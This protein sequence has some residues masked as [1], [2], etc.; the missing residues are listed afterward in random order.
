[1]FDYPKYT[2]YKN[3]PRILVS[4]KNAFKITKIERELLDSGKEY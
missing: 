3:D 2:P 4:C 1:V